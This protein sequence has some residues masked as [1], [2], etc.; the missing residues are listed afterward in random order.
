[1][2]M[3]RGGQSLCHPGVLTSEESRTL[4]F[5]I[6]FY[7]SQLRRSRGAA[8][9]WYSAVSDGQ[10]TEDLSSEYLHARCSSDAC[11]C[12]T[13]GPISGD[14][15]RQTIVAVARTLSR[16]LD[17]MGCMPAAGSCK[18][19]AVMKSKSMKGSKTPAGRPQLEQL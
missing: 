11:G 16:E 2:M 6:S 13:L 4:F 18:Q 17:K 8:I 14:A 1:M 15:G 7:R 19:Y 12:Q 10:R 9:A 3:M 5:H